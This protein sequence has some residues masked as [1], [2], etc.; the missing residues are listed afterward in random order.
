MTPTQLL[1]NDIYFTKVRNVKSPTRANQHDAGIDFFLPSITPQFMEDFLNKNEHFGEI[2]D[3]WQALFQETGGEPF[4]KIPAFSRVLIPSGIKVWILNKAS[5]LVAF[6]KSGLASKHGLTTTAQV[7]DADYTGEVHV[8]LYNSSDKAMLFKEGD[9]IGQFLHLD[10]Y[11]STMVE[12][13]ED[14]YAQLSQNSDRGE[15]GFGSTDK[16]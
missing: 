13:E 2:K 12:V 10:I 6:N 11:L 15:G 5:A 3:R 16:N 9:K 8:G 1:I 14:T 4:I 7:V